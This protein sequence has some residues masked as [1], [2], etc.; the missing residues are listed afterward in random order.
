MV[1]CIYIKHARKQKSHSHSH[2]DIYIYTN[3]VT[4]DELSIEQNVLQ[5][6]NRHVLSVVALA[7]ICYSPAICLSS[8]F[9]RAIIYP[10]CV[11][12]SHIAFYR[13]ALLYIIRN[14]IQHKSYNRW[15]GCVLRKVN[16]PRNV[17]CR[18]DV[19]TCNRKNFIQRVSIRLPQPREWSGAINR[20]TQFGCDNR[21]VPCVSH[22]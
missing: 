2:T 17:P 16:E 18:R 19:W 13:Y 10:N 9:S 15:F 5:Q 12:I 6:T 21:R 8:S 1:N 14:R 20:H 4:L 3:V 7:N 11:H 22:V